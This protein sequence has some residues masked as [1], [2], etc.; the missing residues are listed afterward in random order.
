MCAAP[1]QETDSRQLPPLDRATEIL[2]VGLIHLLPSYWL[3][4]DRTRQRGRAACYVVVWF[5]GL[6]I[7]WRMSPVAGPARTA[8]VVLAIL[9]WLEI[10]TYCL[11]LVL[12]RYEPVAAGSLVL[13]GIFAIQ[14]AFIFAILGE[15]LAEHE[16]VIHAIAT[17]PATDPFDYLYI[18]WTN[19][20]TLGNEYGPVS[21]MARILRLAS[22][23]SGLL[24]LGVGAARTLDLISSRAPAQRT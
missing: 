16:F 1:M 21:D 9:R 8:F 22:V 6:I 12:Q 2:Y 5:V 4:R 23:T 20:T 11:G 15:N 10:A 14:I 19:M 24:L 17:V 18:S 13:I 7:M 3:I